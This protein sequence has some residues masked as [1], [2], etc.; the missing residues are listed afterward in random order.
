[1]QDTPIA[2]IQGLRLSLGFTE[3]IVVPEHSLQEPSYYDEVEKLWMWKFEG[4]DMYIDLGEPLIV[5]ICLIVF[6]PLKAE[7]VETNLKFAL[8]RRGN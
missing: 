4:N 8:C 3:D 2:H 6:W 7:S 5:V 1:M